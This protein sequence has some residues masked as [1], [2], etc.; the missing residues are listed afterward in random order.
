M[1]RAVASAS[2]SSNRR[3]IFMA[4][5]LG[6]L[7][8]ILVYAAFSRGSS[9][10]AGGSGDV[11]VVVAKTDIPAR[12]RITESMLEIKL[13][14]TDELGEFAY[15][16]LASVVGQVTRFPI[17]TNEQV[18]STKIV[19]LSGTSAATSTSR[20]LSFV[21]P[22]GMRGFAINIS[23]VQAGG[24]LL[25]PGDYVDVTVV[26]DVKF[27]NDKSEDSFLVQTILQ[28]IEVLAVSQT[29]VDLVPEA[30]PSS[31][32]Q[33]ARNTEAKPDAA[34]ATVT[35]AL[36]PEQ[37]QKMYLAESNGRVRLSIRPYGDG[38]QQPLDYITELDLFPRNLPNP[39]TQ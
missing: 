20:S 34:A 30:T 24:G 8:A 17:T 33:R 3:Y 5:A 18:L 9:N 38:Q 10:G 31:S 39:F 27:D 21:V 36:T 25:L 32:G 28:N 4:L 1:S 29:V 13:V 22:A 12:T 6:L 23:E 14:T 19:A 16:D 7:G 2:P 37:V 15:S 11:P 26:Y 35:L